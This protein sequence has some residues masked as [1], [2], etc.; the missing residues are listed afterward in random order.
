MLELQKA[1]KSIGTEASVVR[2]SSRKARDYPPAQ[3]GRA[4]N[5]LAVL[6]GE[7]QDR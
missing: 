2:V 4:Q 3:P 5:E 6:V 1:E 7:Q